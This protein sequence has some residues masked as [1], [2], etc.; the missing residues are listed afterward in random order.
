MNRGRHP[1]SVRTLQVGVLGAPTG[2]YMKDLQRAASEMPSSRPTTVEPLS[3]QKLSVWSTGPSLPQA[4]TWSQSGNS[5]EEPKAIGLS[6]CHT[7]LVR[8]MPLGSV[9]QIVFRMNA[10]HAA[11]ASNVQILNP[12]R[13]LEI[14]IDK[15]L[16]LDIAQRAGIQTPRTI[17]CQ[18]RDDALQAWESLGGDCIV[19]PIFGGEGRGIVRVADSDM[20]WRVFSTLE[21]LQ[22]VIY[23]QEFLE[24]EGYDLRLLVVGDELFCVRREN[25]GDWRSNVSRGGKAI[26]HEPTFEQISIAFRACKAIG[27]WMIGVDILPTRDGRNIL[28]ELNAVPGWRATAGALQVDMAH[29]ILHRLHD[30]LE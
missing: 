23:I 19:K 24:S 20:A 8:S 26:I 28:L 17:C 10:L 27:G 16:T 6:D 11:Q 5:M 9:E 12:P 2:W 4:K 22:S 29:L 15:W 21:Q 7:V 3:F 1:K 25:H 30:G 14:A 18:T 13:C